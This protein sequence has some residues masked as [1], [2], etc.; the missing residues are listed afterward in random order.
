[1]DML[2]QI[3][4]LWFIILLLVIVVLFQQRRSDYTPS[5]GA[6]ITLMDLQEFSAFTPEQKTQYLE[7]LNSSMDILNKAKTLENIMATVSILMNETSNTP[8]VQAQALQ[9]PMTAEPKPPM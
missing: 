5:P 9:P 3:S 6:P 7:K 1:M 2:K 4:P 8:P